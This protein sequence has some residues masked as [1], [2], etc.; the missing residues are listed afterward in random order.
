M[1]IAEAVVEVL[2]DHMSFSLVEAVKPGSST[3][4]WRRRWFQIM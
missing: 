4:G 2:Q 3:C 1:E